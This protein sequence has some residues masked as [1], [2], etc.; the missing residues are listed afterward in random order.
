[1]ESLKPCRTDIKERM[2]KLFYRVDPEYGEGVAK[3]VGVVIE[4]ASL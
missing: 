2:V 4:K 3:G 1:V